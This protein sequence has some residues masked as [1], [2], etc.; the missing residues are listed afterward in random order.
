MTFTQ[1]LRQTFN[2]QGQVARASRPGKS[3][4]P[5]RVRFVP[6]LDLME[7]RRA[8]PHSR[9]PAPPTVV[10]VAAGRD[11]GQ[12]QPP[13]RHRHRHHPVRIRDRR[14]D[15]QPVHLRQRRDAGL[16]NGGSVRLLYHQQRRPD[17][18]RPDRPDQGITITRTG[19][20]PFR[21]FDVA[22]TGNLTL[23]GLTLSG[24]TAQG[25]DGGGGAQPGGGSAGL[26]GASSTRAL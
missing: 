14:R 21:I 18:R 6:R 7:D 8:R 1:W 15:H 4:R 2:S 12:R 22:A 20:T 17:N 9:S 16:E 23:K 5:S 25:F 26:G 3:R 13:A 24:G 19:T 11:P 10:R